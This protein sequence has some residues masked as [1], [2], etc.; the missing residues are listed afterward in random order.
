MSFDK[1]VGCGVL[2]I[3]GTWAGIGLATLLINLGLL[4]AAVWVV[5]K[6]LQYT[7]VI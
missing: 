3:F 6:V 7:G 2:S 1:R 5:V 4:A